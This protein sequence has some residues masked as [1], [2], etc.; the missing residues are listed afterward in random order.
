METIAEPASRAFAPVA[1][2][3]YLGYGADGASC[4]PSRSP[5]PILEIHGYN[6]SVI[7]YNGSTHHLGSKLPNILDFMEDWAARNGGNSSGGTKTVLYDGFVDYYDFG[8]HTHH[9]AVRNANHVW[10]STT[11]NADTARFP[12]GPSAINASSVIMEFFRNV[13]SLDEQN[14]WLWNKIELAA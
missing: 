13:P 8:R 1:G 11:G 4:K 6:D 5:Q 9:Y 14:P 3:F 12:E 10:E 2:A 7:P